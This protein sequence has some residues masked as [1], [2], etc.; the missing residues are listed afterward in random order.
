[1]DWKTTQDYKAL[2]A[3]REDM[4]RTDNKHLLKES[5]KAVSQGDLR[6]GI[7]SYCSPG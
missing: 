7:G 3:A 1:M 6:E 5:R 2:G 4:K